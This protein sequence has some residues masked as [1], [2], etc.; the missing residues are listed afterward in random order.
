[1]KAIC[2]Y[3]KQVDFFLDRIDILE[4][5]IESGELD[6]NEND[7]EILEFDGTV[8]YITASGNGK[9]Y[10]GEDDYGLRAL[11]FEGKRNS[12]SN[13]SS[14][15]G[16]RPRKIDGW[17]VEET[18]HPYRGAF[19]KRNTYYKRMYAMDE[20]ENIEHLRVAD[21][22]LDFYM[23]ELEYFVSGEL[24]DTIVDVDRMGYMK[25]VGAS[26]LRIVFDER[27]LP[28]STL[29]MIEENKL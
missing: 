25:G 20:I 21:V 9:Y 10:V 15:L 8:G 4:S 17:Q 13:G 12:F 26:I 29:E 22:N 19:E 2:R 28:E 18:S 6:L 7:G 24:N 11:F 23:S 5:K 27:D 3:Q 14:L 1:M 16:Y